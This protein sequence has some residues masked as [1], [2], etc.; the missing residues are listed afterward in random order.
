MSDEE[1][2]T[3][4][5]DNSSLFASKWFAAAAVAVVLIVAMGVVVTAT[6]LI[7]NGD[8]DAP[9]SSGSSHEGQISEDEYPDDDS[10]QED[11]PRSDGSDSTCGLKDS[12]KNDFTA[13]PEDTDWEIVGTLEAPS[14]TAHGPG[15][16]EDNG[17]RHCYAKSPEGAVMAAVNYVA[18]TTDPLIV[19]DLVEHMYAEGPGKDAVR[20]DLE[21]EGAGADRGTP[22]HTGG[23]RLLAYG[24]DRARVDVALVIEGP[25]AAMGSTPIDLRWE[26]GDWKVVTRD[27]GEMVIPQTVIYSLDGYILTPAEE[28]R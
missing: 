25:N 18:M 14:S 17:F 9:Q 19:P 24:A 5:G 7:D 3:P 27:D 10:R 26:K 2:P 16:S 4:S 1:I 28:G 12:E 6:K 15:K 20:E 13:W 8:P 11:V 22:G 21:E 23:A